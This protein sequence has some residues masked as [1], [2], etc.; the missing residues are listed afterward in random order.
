MHSIINDSIDELLEML[1]STSDEIRE[2]A[3]EEAKKIKYA[4]ILVL[5]YKLSAWEN[6]AIALSAMPD[7][8]LSPHADSLLMWVS[9]PNWPGAETINERLKKFEDVSMLKDSVE[10]YVITSLL[11]D[12]L[13]NIADLLENEKL[14]ASLS[15]DKC[16]VLFD[17]F[18]NY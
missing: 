15:R 9:D 16:K 1:S 17:R 13:I 6:C 11:N 4:S 7:E 2:R 5:P 3:I 14:R 12:S 10:R 8:A 18:A